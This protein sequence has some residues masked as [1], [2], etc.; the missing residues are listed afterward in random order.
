MIVLT[1]TLGSLVAAQVV[2]K[3]GSDPTVSSV[4]EEHNLVDPAPHATRSIHMSKTAVDAWAR[5]VFA[6]NTSRYF[7]WG[8]GGSTEAAAAWAAGLSNASGGASVWSVDSSED[9]FDQLRADSPLIQQAEAQGVLQ[10]LYADVG[11][12]GLWGKPDDYTAKGE[13]KKRALG[14]RYALDPIEAV[15]GEFDV[16]LVDGRW[17]VACG[18]AALKHVKPSSI[19]MVHD[20]FYKDSGKVSNRYDLNSSQYRV[21]FDWYDLHKQANELAVL[22]P[23]PEAVQ[24]AKSNDASYRAALAAAFGLMGSELVASERSATGPLQKAAE[25]KG[26]TKAVGGAALTKGTKAVGGAALQPEARS[27]S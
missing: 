7:E 1:L 6:P 15:G 17:R 11:K 8:S 19:V 13:D 5:L 3:S 2:I 24:K 12:V 20:F 23:K 25:G 14:M 4:L 10:L 26:T 21:F 16:L 18:L 27:S 22:T 9:W